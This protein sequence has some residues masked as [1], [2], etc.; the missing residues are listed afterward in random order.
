[1]LYI[2]RGVDEAIVVGDTVVRVLEVCFG[3]VR[4]AISSPD[5]HSYREVVLQCQASEEAEYSFTPSYDES[6]SFFA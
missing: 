4:L 5:G 2:E 6:L 3:E 1:M